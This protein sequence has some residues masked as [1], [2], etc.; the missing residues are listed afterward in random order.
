MV[1]DDTFKPSAGQKM[2][3]EFYVAQQQIYDDLLEAVRK[4][5]PAE[6]LAEFESVF[7]GH[8]QSLD[9]DVSPFLYKILFADDEAE[10]LNTLKRSCYIFVNNWDLARQGDMLHALLA[11]FKQPSLDKSTL[12]P[13][14][15]RLRQW[16][17]NFAHSKDFEELQ[18]FATQ[19]IGPIE[20]G[21]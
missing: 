19:R 14:L 13:S 2:P 11:L 20:T 9:A 16:L 6:A 10:F 1:V 15:R 18:L 7:F 17:K 8:T 3:P 21:S 4:S 12:S 5:S